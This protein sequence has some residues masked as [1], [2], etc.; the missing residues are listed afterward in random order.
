MHLPT[1]SVCHCPASKDGA[2]GAVEAWALA[3]PSG[4]EPRPPARGGKARR[5]LPRVAAA[6]P[7]VSDKREALPAPAPPSSNGGVAREGES[8]RGAPEREDVGNDPERGEHLRDA[9]VEFK[10]C[11]FVERRVPLGG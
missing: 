5:T 10:R 4:G 2:E 7:Q 11:L 8:P 3:V 1:M 6:V 9:L